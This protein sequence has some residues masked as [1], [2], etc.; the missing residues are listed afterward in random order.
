MEQPADSDISPAVASGLAAQYFDGKSTRAHAVVLRVAAGQV[1]IYG[2]AAERTEPLNAVEIS[3]R[4]RHGPRRITFA[5]GAFVDTDN[6]AAFDTMLRGAGLHDSTVVRWQ[7]SWRL[8]FAAICLTVLT[9]AAGYVWG[10]PW[11]SEKAAALIPAGAERQMGEAALKSLEGDFFTESKLPKERQE[12][13]RAEFANA[14]QRA[15]GDTAPAY[16]L[17]FKKSKI[18]PNAFALPGGF[19]VMTDELVALSK[20]DSAIFG[21]LAHELGHLHHNHM[22]RNVI[23]ASVVGG[24][25]VVIWG[26]VGTIAAGV[27]AAVLQSRYSR[28]FETEADDY[29]L[30]FMQ[31][32]QIAP[33][34]IAALFRELQKKDGG[35]IPEFF[36]SHPATDE[37]IRRFEGQGR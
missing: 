15:L 2:P 24:V 29:A 32:A 28:E 3:E 22:M 11:V 20:D 1:S 13:L 26:D 7:Q 8:T 23:A 10:L 16:T 27:P 12:M 9:L 17:L 19:I 36:R 31:R 33:G 34:G 18:G 35:D 21:V 14:V 4:T 37:R 6:R 5:D 25:A 30:D